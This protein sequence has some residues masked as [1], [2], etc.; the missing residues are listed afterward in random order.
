[1]AENSSIIQNETLTV[2]TATQVLP[3]SKTLRNMVQESVWRY[4]TMLDRPD[5]SNL[6]ELFMS[7]I[8]PPMLEMVLQ[9][10]G[11]NQSKAANILKISRGT[12]RKKMQTYG[13][14]PKKK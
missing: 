5:V 8:E 3:T 13:M 4:L 2:S 11:Q 7:E 9:Y 1:M 6:Y 14:L 10:V 12:L